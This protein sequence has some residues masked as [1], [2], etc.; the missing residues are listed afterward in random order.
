V[1]LSARVPVAESASGHGRDGIALV[2]HPLELGDLGV[3][4]RRPGRVADSRG[5]ERGTLDRRPLGE[6]EL[7]I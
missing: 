7:Q 3:E 6:I 1:D 2:V 4:K 5:S